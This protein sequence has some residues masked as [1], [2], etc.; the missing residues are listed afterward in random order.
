MGNKNQDQRRTSGTAGEA[1][2]TQQCAS[3]PVALLKKKK[4][5]PVLLI[6][7]HYGMQYVRERSWRFDVTFCFLLKAELQVIFFSP[8]FWGIPCCSMCVAAR[9]LFGFNC[10]G[11]A[12]RLSSAECSEWR[13][14]RLPTYCTS[15]SILPLSVGI[16]LVPTSKTKLTNTVQY[17][18]IL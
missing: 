1:H 16:I 18:I 8:F 9:S 3:N 12:L 2:F 14:T 5:R 13:G 6:D 4:R 11:N 15:R 7:L 10:D 17:G